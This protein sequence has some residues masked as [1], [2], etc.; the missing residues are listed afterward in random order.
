MY[1]IVNFITAVA[2]GESENPMCGIPNPYATLDASGDWKLINKSGLNFSIFFVKILLRSKPA[3]NLSILFF[4]PCFP[5]KIGVVTPNLIISLTWGYFLDVTKIL[6]LCLSFCI[7]YSENK[8]CFGAIV[9][10]QIFKYFDWIANC[11]K[12]FLA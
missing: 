11:N 10:N 2:C 4:P 9:S 5:T 8:Y 1:G 7:K 12:Y 6:C 3:N